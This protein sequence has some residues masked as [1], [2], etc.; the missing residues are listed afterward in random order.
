MMKRMIEKSKSEENYKY[1]RVYTY[2]VNDDKSI[3]N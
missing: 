2:F 1:T 3:V